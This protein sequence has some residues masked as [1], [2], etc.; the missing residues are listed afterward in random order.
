MIF[1]SEVVLAEH[2]TR[3]EILSRN[4]HFQ[5]SAASFDRWAEPL[6]SNITSVIAENLS[7]LVASDKVISH[8]WILGGNA[9]FAVSVQVLSFGPDPSGDVSLTALWL[10]STPGGESIALQRARYSQSRSTSEPV[11]TVAAMSNLLGDLS[12]DIASALQ[13][14]AATGASA[15]H[16]PGEAL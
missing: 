2:L 1:V 5:V 8:P 16:E 13:I 12:M 4:R 11:A 10:I 15:K 7:V 3:K 9:D 6:E 14:A